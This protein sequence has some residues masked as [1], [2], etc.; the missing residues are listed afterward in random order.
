MASKVATKNAK[1]TAGARKVDSDDLEGCPLSK[2]ELGRA[3]WG[4]VSH[5]W[6]DCIHALGPLWC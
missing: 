6:P 1:T 3:S 4:L 2:G 5:S